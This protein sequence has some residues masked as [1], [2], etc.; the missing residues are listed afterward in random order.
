MPSPPSSRTSVIGHV[1]L[2]TILPIAR[3]Y[4]CRPTAEAVWGIFDPNRT[5]TGRA[6]TEIAYDSLLSTWRRCSCIC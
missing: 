4:F 6:L 1:S 2:C 5:F 3:R